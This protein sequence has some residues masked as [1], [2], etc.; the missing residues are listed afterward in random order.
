MYGRIGEG[1]NRTGEHRSGLDNEVRRLL[2]RWAALADRIA[3]AIKFA[4][5]WDGATVS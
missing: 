4:L 1:A 2:L 5:I 3:Y